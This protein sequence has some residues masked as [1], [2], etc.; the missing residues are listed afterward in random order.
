MSEREEFEKWWNSLSDHL[1]P[2]GVVAAAWP[3][4]DDCWDTW[5]AARAPLLE[6]IA[7]LEKLAD[8]ISRDCNN[9]ALERNEWHSK[10]EH[11]RAQVERL[12]A[13]ERD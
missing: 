3:D 1:H 7:E 6:R 13:G 8:A 4:K 10:A 9:T 5:Q 2:G 11:L 12:E